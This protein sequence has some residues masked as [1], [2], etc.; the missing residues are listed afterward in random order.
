MSKYK[1]KKGQMVCRYVRTYDA[2]DPYRLIIGHV[3]DLLQDGVIVHWY[4][5]QI[6]SNSRS[7]YLGGGC[8]Q[9]KDLALLHNNQEEAWIHK[10]QAD[11]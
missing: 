4:N 9:G 3:V 2:L 8:Y 5:N 7:W 6:L 11:E 1:F 10:E